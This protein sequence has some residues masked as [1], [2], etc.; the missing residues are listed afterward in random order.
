M[1]TK[2]NLIEIK[3]NKD[4]EK[5]IDTLKISLNKDRKILFG[6]ELIYSH[7]DSEGFENWD[8]SDLII[9]IITS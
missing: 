9:R 1:K 7:T 5:I 8:Q 2:E 3:S 4:L 6:R